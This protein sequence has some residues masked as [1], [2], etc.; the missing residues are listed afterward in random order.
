[1]ARLLVGHLEACKRFLIYLGTTDVLGQSLVVDGERISV[2]SFNFDSRSLLLNTAMGVL[3]ENS[4]GPCQTAFPSVS[5]VP[6]VTTEGR[7][8]WGE[9][10]TIA[11]KPAI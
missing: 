1:M 7:I 10:T 11:S 3:I 9:A 2:G 8:A 5:S 6:E 4:S